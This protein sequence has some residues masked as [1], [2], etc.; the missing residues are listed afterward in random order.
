MEKLKMIPL[1][2]NNSVGYEHGQIPHSVRNDAVA[3]KSIEKGSGGEAAASLPL[4]LLEIACHSE[5]REESAENINKIYNPI[6]P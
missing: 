1:F 6:K 5:R 4:S 3:F 2:N